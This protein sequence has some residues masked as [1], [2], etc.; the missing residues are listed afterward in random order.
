MANP[1]L[2]GAGG[3]A[4]AVAAEIDG[5][6]GLAPRGVLLCFDLETFT[7]AGAA[8]AIANAARYL[9]AR[10]GEIS[11]ILGIS[12]PVYVLFTR[13]D[14][15]PFFAEFVRN[16]NLEEAGQVVGATLPI[17]AAAAGG[18]YAEEETRRLTGAFNLLFHSFCD[19]RLRL[20]PREGDA[21]KLPQA[22]E[23]PREFRKLRNSLVQFLVD[24]GRPSQFRASPFLR[25]FYFSGVRP[26][27]A[28]ETPVCA[29]GRADDSGGACRSRRRDAHVP[30]RDSGRAESAAR[31]G[32]S[33]RRTPVEKCRSGC[34]SGIC[35][36]T[37]S[38]PTRMRAPP[39]DRAPRPAW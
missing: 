11:E 25:G 9:Q 27:A 8:E 17:R 33:R 35:S 36:T 28:A 37:W 7:R 30:R 32:A 34:S 13:A 31:R 15:M 21:T 10:L 16:L 2:E 5:R 20:L 4:A 22:Y 23:F 6:S 12:F 29:S 18:V 38:W 24:V 39:A 1:Q 26:V 14:R 3:E 19:Q